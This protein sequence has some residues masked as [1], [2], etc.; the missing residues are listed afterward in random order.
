MSYQDLIYSL[1]EGVAII[2]LNRPARMNAL[3]PQPGK[4]IAPRLRRG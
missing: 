3:S 4:G 2:T 1:D